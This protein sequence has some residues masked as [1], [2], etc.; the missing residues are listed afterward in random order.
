MSRHLILPDTVTIVQISP[1]DSNGYEFH[2]AFKNKKFASDYLQVQD[3]RD[4]YHVF[5]APVFQEV[6][7]EI[8]QRIAALAKL[9]D[10][11]KALLGLVPTPPGGNTRS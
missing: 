6:T 3:R 9:T 2:K 10:V 7:E 5:D 1:E 4:E 8:E 11:E